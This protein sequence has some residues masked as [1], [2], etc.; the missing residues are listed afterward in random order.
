MASFKEHCA[1]G[2]W[3]GSLIVTND[4]KAEEGMGD[5]GRITKL[6]DLPAKKVLTGYI[7]KAMELNDAGVKKPTAPQ[8]KTPKPLIIPDYLEKALQGNAAAR[9]TFE[10]FSP[11]HKRE[12]VEWIAEAKTEATRTKRLQTAMEW[13]AE[14]KP[15]NWKYMNC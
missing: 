15:R 3:K 8:P 13:M 9:A 1:F 7:K 11:S 6:S 4:G 5:L 14:G 2:F 10:K 12:Y